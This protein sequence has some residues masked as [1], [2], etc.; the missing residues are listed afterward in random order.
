MAETVSSQGQ[1]LTKM[2]TKVKCLL[3]SVQ[4]GIL[5]W[6]T[7]QLLAKGALWKTT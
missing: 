2:N 5:P 1:I 7:N 6:E 4:S 3:V